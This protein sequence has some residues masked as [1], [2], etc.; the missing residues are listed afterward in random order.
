MPYTVQYK[1]EEGQPLTGD[2]F[3]LDE[4]DVQVGWVSVGTGGTT[5]PA[6]LYE[7][8]ANFRA[9]VD[10]YYDIIEPQLFNDRLNEFVFVK[11][12]PIALYVIGAAAA[13]FMFTRIFKK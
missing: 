3:L 2:L 4:N 13:A 9:H 10:G 7:Q 1:N 12:P 11:K 6:D 5:V 8:T